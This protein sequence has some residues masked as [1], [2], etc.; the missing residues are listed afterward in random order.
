M[1]CLKIIK[2]V[3]Y[4]AKSDKFESNDIIVDNRFGRR[5]EQDVHLIIFSQGFGE[6]HTDA[7][8]AGISVGDESENML[9]GKKIWKKLTLHRRRSHRRY[10]SRTLLRNESSRRSRRKDLRP[11][12][13]ETA[14]N[15][16]TVVEGP[17]CESYCRRC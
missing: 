12:R 15:V 4:F 3:I 9:D 2:K 1:R 14:E 10:P 7:D 16:R 8:D 11:R 13:I 17:R 6:L 5:V